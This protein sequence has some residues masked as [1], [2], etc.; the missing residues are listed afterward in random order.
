MPLP[1]PEPLLFKY[2]ERAAAYDRYGRNR[3]TERG[4][5]ITF[6]T[7]EKSTKS[8]GNSERKGSSSSPATEF[9]VPSQDLINEES[10]QE[11]YLSGP[12]TNTFSPFQLSDPMIYAEVRMGFH[13]MLCHHHISTILRCYI[14]MQAAYIIKWKG[15]KGMRKV[16]LLVMHVPSAFSDLLVIA[17]SFWR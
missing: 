3:R 11:E 14:G 15:M 2:I 5:H 9:R 7:R 12:C 8:N 4:H 16:R 6:C 1:F 10:R 13:N 17:L